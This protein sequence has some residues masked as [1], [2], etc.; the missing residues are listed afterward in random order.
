MHILLENYSR[1]SSIPSF[2]NA[3]AR[4]LG[5][6]LPLITS[7]LQAK[8]HQLL[9]LLMN[10]DSPK[11]L[12]FKCLK[13]P[14]LAL[15]LLNV[16]VFKNLSI[17]SSLTCPIQP[18]PFHHP[19]TSIQLSFIHTRCLNDWHYLLLLSQ[20]LSILLNSGRECWT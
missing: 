19:W 20:L 15:P 9:Q 8:H 4:S 10:Y 16:F 14:V 12:S 18:K 17:H 1:H 7:V 13:P 5:R 2:P 11:E 3:L 6:L